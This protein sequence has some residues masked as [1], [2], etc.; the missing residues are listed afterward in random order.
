[1]KQRKSIVTERR[2]KIKNLFAEHEVLEVTQVSRQFGVSPLTIRRD[3]DVL[4]EEGFIER[5]HGGGRLLSENS[6]NPPKPLPF[7]DK[8]MLGKY[9]KHEI[10]AY[11]ASL[12]KDEDTVFLNAG[13]TTLEVI[14]NIKYKNVVIVTNNALASSVMGDC[15]AALISTGGEYNPHNQSYT[16]LMALSLFQKMNATVCVLGSNGITRNEGLTTSNYPESII[17]EEMLRRCK[18]RRIAAAD[19]SKIGRV[20]NFTSVPISSIDILVTDSS[21]D[22]QELKKIRAAGVKV[23]LADN[24]IFK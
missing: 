8:N 22:P 13:S 20:F 3:F 14:R 2:L 9:Q 16:G 24:Q 11:V 18:G 5:V 15:S 19:G 6:S 4:A 23:V 17:N 10:S 7:K 21:A 1:M 12:I